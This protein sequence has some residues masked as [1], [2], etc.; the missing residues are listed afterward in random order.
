MVARIGLNSA[1]TGEEDDALFGGEVRGV[2][3][4]AFERWIAT[5]LGA[6]RTRA[7]MARAFDHGT[8]LGVLA[9]VAIR[10]LLRRGVHQAATRRR[11]ARAAAAIE[12]A[13]IPWRGVRHAM[14][15]WRSAARIRALSRRAPRVAL[16]AALLRVG[17]RRSPP[18]RA[19]GRAG[20]GDGAELAG[21]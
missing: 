16:P 7:L 14:R 8:S 3:E 6:Q 21:G 2:L 15:V 1:E 11:I 19:G 10:V 9:R 17:A 13:R 12:A 5:A 20:V 4:E 18:H